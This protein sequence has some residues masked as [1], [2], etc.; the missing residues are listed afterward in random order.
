MLK[1]AKCVEGLVDSVR[2]GLN[3]VGAGDDATAEAGAALVKASIDTIVAI[4]RLVMDYNVGT[5]AGVTKNWPIYKIARAHMDKLLLKSAGGLAMTDDARVALKPSA[6]TLDS[7]AQQLAR[8]AK[9]FALEAS[10]AN[11]ADF[12]TAIYELSTT[13][14]GFFKVT[15]EPANDE[16][17]CE[18]DEDEP[19]AAAD[20]PWGE[21]D[22]DEPA[23]EEQGGEEEEDEPADDDE[24]LECEEEEDEPADE[25]QGDEEEEEEQGGRT[26]AGA[27]ASPAGAAAADDE[28]LADDDDMQSAPATSR[29]VRTSA[30]FE[31]SG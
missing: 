4:S 2:V 3:N 31:I 15:V 11:T 22:E 17:V 8:Q 25:E 12:K 30:R 29:R 6:V 16:P 21:E 27:A 9:A 14:K 24:D 18:E 13:A 28:E 7:A 1:N 5:N 26:D 10:E 23:D 20:E 19:A